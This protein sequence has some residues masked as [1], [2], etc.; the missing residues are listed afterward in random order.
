[1]NKS[2][3]IGHWVLTLILAPLMSQAIEYIFGKDPHQVVGLLEVYPITVIFSIVFS[4]PTFLIYLACFYFLSKHSIHLALSKAILI[5]ISIIG[6]FVTEKI[7][8][9][10]MSPDVIIAYSFTA[11]IVGLLLNLNKT[12]TKT[13]NNPINR[14]TKGLRILL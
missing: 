12:K 6:I 1:M 4:L 11:F 9:G 14:C 10:S 8:Q 5:S 13:L 3:V 7:I 2:F